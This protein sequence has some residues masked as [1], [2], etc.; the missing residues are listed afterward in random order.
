VIGAW[1]WVTWPERTAFEFV[2][3]IGIQDEL[4]WAEMLQTNQDADSIGRRFIKF[5][6]P[7]DWSNVTP[8]SRSLAEI[9][10]GRRRFQTTVQMTS[11]LGWE[12]VTERG[13]V[14]SPSNET[15]NEVM[16]KYHMAVEQERLRLARE[17]EM[18]R[19]GR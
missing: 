2:R 9:L 6:A 8:Q 17:H 13:A 4:A 12:F 7:S 10:L 11:E 3:R 15:A 16:E 18:L 5:Y 19:R 14:I 1:W